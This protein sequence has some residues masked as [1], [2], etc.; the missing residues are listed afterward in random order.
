MTHEYESVNV[1]GMYFCGTLGHGKDFK[2]A[3]GGFI[4]GFRYT[5][6]A[7]HRI[8]EEKHESGSAWPRTTFRL[9]DQITEFA[10]HIMDRQ[11]SASGPYQV[12]AVP[13]L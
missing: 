11:N 1:P 12:R 5:A 3:A 8:L 2:R 9:P 6:R 13:S 4:H 10:Q 7:L